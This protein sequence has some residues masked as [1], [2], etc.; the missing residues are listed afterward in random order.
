MDK[1]NY[2]SWFRTNDIE[3]HFLENPTKTSLPLIRLLYKDFSIV[4]ADFDKKPE[5]MP[6]SRFLSL[7]EMDL[8]ADQFFAAKTP[9]GNL[10]LFFLVSHPNMTMTPNW[11]AE[12]VLS[13]ISD[14]YHDYLDT[15]ASAM[16][17][18]YVNKSVGDALMNLF[19]FRNASDAMPCKPK[20]TLVRNFHRMRVSR[21]DFMPN[22]FKRFIRGDEKREKFMR[23]LMEIHQLANT[24]YNLPCNLLATNC[25]ASPAAVSKWLKELEEL[26]FIRCSDKSYE[27]FKKARTYV[28]MGKLLAFLRQNKSVIISRSGNKFEFIPS[29]RYYF[30]LNY[31]RERLSVPIDEL[32]WIAS[33][34]IAGIN[35][36]GLNQIKRCWKCFHNKMALGKPIFKKAA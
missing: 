16:S 31:A 34:E 18:C 5:N 8:P 26:G 29:Q 15:S 3:S 24:D 13:K 35:N 17:Q 12:F 2:L 6:W 30:L 21:S 32:L 25:G 10:K 22:K 4:V 1:G 14:K 7:L 11:S 27:R 33:G 9:S 36:K 28:A 23:I 20:L 19:N